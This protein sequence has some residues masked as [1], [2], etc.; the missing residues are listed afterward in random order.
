MQLG[1]GLASK[2]YEYINIILTQKQGR[3]QLHGFFGNTENVLVDSKSKVG[4]KAP[5]LMS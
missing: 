3:R 5:S 1:E 2:I 4:D